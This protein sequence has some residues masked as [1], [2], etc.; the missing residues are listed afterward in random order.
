MDKGVYCLL[1]RNRPGEIR[2]GS[3]GSVPFAGGWH[4]YV[5]SALGS[6]GLARAERHVR[7]SRER[8]RSPRW[9]VDYL[10]L[11]PRFTLSAIVSAPTSR[12]VECDLARL[13]SECPVPGFGCS[14]C[15]CRSHLFWRPE[16]PTEEVTAAFRALGL[17]CRYQ[18][19]QE[20]E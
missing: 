18:N 8:D 12:G 14:D 10:L 2:V 7:L 6:G 19:Y 4:C 16:N 1:F 13:I 15:R 11:D 5:G 20:R 3:L 17:A 9:H